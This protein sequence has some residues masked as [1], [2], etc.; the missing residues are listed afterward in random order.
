MGWTSR[1]FVKENEPITAS[2]QDEISA[3]VAAGNYWNE[4]SASCRDRPETVARLK[5]YLVAYWNFEDGPGSSTATDATG[6]GHDGT[7]SGEREDA[8]KWPGSPLAG[9]AHCQ[10]F[11]GVAEDNIDIPNK[12]GFPSGAQS[13]TSMAWVKA[14]LAI[15]TP[16][17]CSWGPK[18]I[19]YCK[20]LWKIL[21]V[22]R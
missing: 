16:R 6:N 22:S 15:R 19:Y 21:L 8:T 5:E 7:W 10:D 20:V 14:L 1:F 12:I 13:R 18:S 3:C 2:A 17:N 4:A 11:Q 9:G